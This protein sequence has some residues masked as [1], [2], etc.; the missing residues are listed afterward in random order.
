MAEHSPANPPTEQGRIPAMDTLPIAPKDR[1]PSDC[2]GGHDMRLHYPMAMAM[3]TRG[4]AAARYRIEWGCAA[5]DAGPEWS[6]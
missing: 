5:C 3:T 1:P 4:V 2:P 6:E